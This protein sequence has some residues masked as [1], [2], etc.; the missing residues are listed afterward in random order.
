M[1]IIG[2]AGLVGSIL[3]FILSFVP[4]SQIAVG[5]PMAYVGIL[6]ALSLFFCLVPFA[7]Y[8]LRKPHWRAENNDF[9]PF[10]WQAEGG[11]PGIPTDSS[12]HPSVLAAQARADTPHEPGNTPPAAGR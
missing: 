6:I 5:S 12:A 8:A 11:H 10:T 2:G 1:W 7:I 4:P 3:A 9:A